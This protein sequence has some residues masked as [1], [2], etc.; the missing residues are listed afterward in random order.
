MV[1][2][3]GP[4]PDSPI[5][6]TF[7]ACISRGTSLRRQLQAVITLRSRLEHWFGYKET[8]NHMYQ[9]LH[10]LCEERQQNQSQDKMEFY[11]DFIDG[12]IF[13]PIV[14]SRRGYRSA[15]YDPFIGLSTDGFDAFENSTY[16]CWPMIIMIH[17]LPP[18]TRLLVR[19]VVPIAFA[20]GPK[21]PVRVD[22]FLFPFIREMNDL[23]AGGGTEFEFHDGIVRKI[24]IHLMWEKGNGPAIQ[25]LGSFLGAKR[26]HMC[27]YCSISGFNCPHCHSYFFP[28]KVWIPIEGRRGQ[29]SLYNPAALP[30]RD[31]DD[32]ERTLESLANQMLTSSTRRKLVTETG[33]K[34]QNCYI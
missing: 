2:I 34:Q 28:S 20:R 13:K 12:S 17:N 22:I 3:A 29:F 26:K 8:C 7:L 18:W 4:S 24:M 16:D 23:N 9:Y 33:V 25:K 32:I 10:A 21:E 30:S 27:R 31:P 1:F 11:E 6:A 15:K 5:E 19:N 14:A